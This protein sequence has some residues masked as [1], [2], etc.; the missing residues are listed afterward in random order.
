MDCVVTP[1]P[2]YP[3]DGRKLPDIYTVPGDLRTKLQGRF[4]QFPLF[5]FWG[6]GA[7]I[8]STE[9]I[10]EAAMYVEAKRN[11]TLT[12]VYLPHLDYD[13]QRFG[14]ADPR[15]AKALGEIDAVFEKLRAC[16]EGRGARVV[17]ISEYGITP[18]ATPVHINRVL[19]GAGL[20]A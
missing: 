19:R 13:L 14:P 20:I 18:V 4:G 17:V 16:F 9:W 11:P 7:D 2:M 1:R 6:P 3:A 8:R 15:I 12:L 5:H 10:A